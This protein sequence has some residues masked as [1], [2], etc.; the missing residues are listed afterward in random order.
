MIRS[1]VTFAALIAAGPLI[2]APTT[3][4]PEFVKMAGSS[5]LYEK[6]SSQMVLKV[7][8]NPQVRSYAQMMIT[9][10]GKTTQD[11]VAAAKTDGLPPMKPMLV[12]A[13]AKLIADLKKTKQAD[14]EKVYVQQQVKSHEEALALHTS[15]S[16]GGDKP[17]LKRAATGAVPIVKAHLEQVKTMQSSMSGI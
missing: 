17:A 12:P 15:Y 14:M 7:A 8:K 9:D 11:V 4:A 6:Q 3:V 5:D 2:A 16:Q 10:H 13:H 1:I